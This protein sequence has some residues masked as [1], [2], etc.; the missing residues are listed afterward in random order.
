MWI[1]SQNRNVLVNADKFSVS[2]EHGVFRIYS[3]NYFLGE[4][5]AREKAMKVMD[6][7]ESAIIEN[8]I[9]KPKSKIIFYMPKDDEVDV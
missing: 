3:V 2:K 8:E 7:I 9:A 1:R 4:Y 6:M 5:S